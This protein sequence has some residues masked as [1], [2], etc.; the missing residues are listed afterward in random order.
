MDSNGDKLTARELIRLELQ[1]KAVA[2]GRY[3]NILL[4]IR[5]GYILT[6]YG[7]LL[8][9]VGRG[10]E[11]SVIVSK[12]GLALASFLTIFILSTVLAIIDVS[13]RIRQLRVV[14]A[15]DRLMDISLG[16]A[17]DKAADTNELESLL[18]IV[19]ERSFPIG[20]RRFLTAIALIGSLY[21]AVP[22]LGFILYML[23]EPNKA[24]A[25]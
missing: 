5:G 17:T 2:T 16:L 25:P 22:V 15:Y 18:H 3:D 12:P 8:L 21:I 11:L 13:F 24:L 10:N 9:F 4:R 14:T 23:V 6:L 7:S 19:G 1:G 20:A